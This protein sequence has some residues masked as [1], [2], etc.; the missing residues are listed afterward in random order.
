[1]TERSTVQVSYRKVEEVNESGNYVVME[2]PSGDQR[3]QGDSPNFKSFFSEIVG[4]NLEL[5]RVNEGGDLEGTRLDVL[6]TDINHEIEVGDQKSRVTISDR[7]GVGGGDW[8]IKITDKFG[9][10]FS[11]SRNGTLDIWMYVS[12][13]NGCWWS[14][15]NIAGNKRSDLIETM[16]AGF[17]AAVEFAH[18]PLHKSEIGS[19]TN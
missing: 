10:G 4:D 3:I 9:K 11:S 17:N 5:M 7:L 15:L 6:A 8:H 18:L 19:A 16:V 1:M 2:N 14:Y 12:R 13:T